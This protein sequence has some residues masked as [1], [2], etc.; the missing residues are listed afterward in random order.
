MSSSSLHLSIRED[1]LL[2]THIHTT[3]THMYT[4]THAE[5]YGSSTMHLMIV[6]RKAYQEKA[7][8]KCHQASD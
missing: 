5:T 1:A 6:Q 4:E 8:E 2:R 3:Y 7:P